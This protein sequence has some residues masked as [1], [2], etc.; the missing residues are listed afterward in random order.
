MLASMQL[1]I[2][3]QQSV[4]I[5]WIW[6][7]PLWV[8]TESVPRRGSREYMNETSQRLVFSLTWPCISVRRVHRDEYIES[9]KSLM[10]QRYPKVRH[11]LRMFCQERDLQTTYL[12][13]PT[14]GVGTSQTHETLGRIP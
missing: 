11:F 5:V 1:G 13:T 14:M 10:D 8:K 7:I 12:V 9:K 2:P 3:M 4:L 6:F